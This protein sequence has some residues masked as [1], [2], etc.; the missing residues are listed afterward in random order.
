M[1]A[2]H[3]GMLGDLWESVGFGSTTP[4]R[5][6]AAAQATTLSSSL[7]DESLLVHIMRGRAAAPAATPASSEPRADGAR[8]GDG[9]GDASSGRS[10]TAV[11]VGRPALAPAPLRRAPSKPMAIPA[12]LCAVDPVAVDGAAGAQ[13]GTRC[14]DP[15]APVVGTVNRHV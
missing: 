6:S 13:L 11:L 15:H 5:A 14:A 7:P 3:A 1:S 10:G 12:R 4:P 9:R 8:G 2:P